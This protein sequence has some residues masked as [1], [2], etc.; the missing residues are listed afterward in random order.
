MYTKQVAHVPAVGERALASRDV[1]TVV[2]RLHIAAPVGRVWDTIMFYE[3]IDEPPPLHLRWLLPTPVRTEGRKSEV[4]DTATCVY[5][6]GNLIKRVTR[7]EHGRLYGFEVTAQTLALGGRMRLC[8]GAYS[9]SAT[10][11][12]GTEVALTTR[13]VGGRRPAWL[14]GPIERVVAHMF[15]RHI[16]RAMR[17]AAESN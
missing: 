2:T 3:E 13:Y 10:D 12:G 7:I 1:R 15:H 5:V 4:G 11:D 8:G 9:L 17:R 6:G 16:L 14:W